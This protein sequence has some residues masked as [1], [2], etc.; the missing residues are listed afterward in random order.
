MHVHRGWGDGD[1]CVCLG[2]G[3][4]DVFFSHECSCSLDTF[5]CSFVNSYFQALLDA[6]ILCFICFLLWII[7]TNRT[8]KPQLILVADVFI[9]EI[10]S[11]PLYSAGICASYRIFNVLITFWEENETRHSHSSHFSN[12][13]HAP[14]SLFIIPI[15]P[16]ALKGSIWSCCQGLWTQLAEWLKHRK[17]PMCFLPIGSMLV[18]AVNT[19]GKSSLVQ[20]S[21]LRRPCWN[22]GCVYSYTGCN[23][24]D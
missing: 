22:T 21:L 4:D 19:S 16:R 17:I 2:G 10:K 23:F 15:F 12:Q 6:H 3:C 1:V 14:W 5:V 24:W 8:L 9:L 13:S 18:S 11:Q 20:L 7:I